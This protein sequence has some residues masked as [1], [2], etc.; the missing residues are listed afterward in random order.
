[1]EDRGRED[2][3]DGSRQGQR[4]GEVGRHDVRAPGV[5]PPPRRRG[6][7][8]GGVHGDHAA[9]GEPA[10]DDLGHPPGP[11]PRVEDPLVAGEGQALD[12]SPAPAERRVRDPLVGRRVPLAGHAPRIAARTCHPVTGLGIKWLAL[13]R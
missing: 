4:P 6:H 1:M 3:I 5:E 10:E 7:G 9:R 13:F 12:H 11:A 2:G 8:G